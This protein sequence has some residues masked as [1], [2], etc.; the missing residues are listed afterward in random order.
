MCFVNRNFN[1]LKRC[2]IERGKSNVC[3]TP[4]FIYFLCYHRIYGKTMKELRDFWFSYF[5]PIL[6]MRKSKKQLKVI[7]SIL[8]VNAGL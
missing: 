4:N 1:K 7:N 3:A 5:R 2:D 8:I 6:C